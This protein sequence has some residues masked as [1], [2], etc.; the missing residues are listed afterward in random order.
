MIKKRLPIIL[1]GLILILAI[2]L[3]SCGG[4]DTPVDEPTVDEPSV[5]EP[6]VDEP[7]V[8]EPAAD[9][10]V[11]L[12]VGGVK[13]I[14]C[15]NLFTCSQIWDFGDYVFEGF[16]SRGRNLACSGEPRLAESMEVSEDGLT[17]TV[18]LREGITFSDGT[19]YNAHSA[20]E[21]ATWLKAN[22]DLEFWTLVTGFMTSAE[23]LDD[24][25]VQYTTE[26]PLLSFPNLDA[27]WWY[28]LPMHIWGDLEPD[29]VWNFEN[30]PPVGTGPYT[31]E[32]WK[33]GEYIIF[34]AREDYHLGKPP[35]DRIVY[36]IYSTWDGLIQAFLAD[37]IDLTVNTIPGVYYDTL[38]ADD[39]TGLLNLP[40]GQMHFLAFNSMEG[41]AKHQAID[42]LAIRQAIDL[43]ID[44]QH[45]VDIAMLGH[46]TTCPTSWACGE[47]YKDEVNPDLT[48][49]PYDPDEAKAILSDAGYTDSDGDGILESADG[50][51]L[52]FRLFYQ[53]EDALHTA[54]SQLLSDW[55]SAIGIDLEVVAMEV[56][57]LFD[58]I[59]GE[60]DY[61]IAL[62]AFT[63]DIDPIAMDFYYSCWSADAAAAAWNMGG[64]CNPEFDDAIFEA[65]SAAT[66]EEYED[67]HNRAQA[68]L[69]RDLPTL[70]IAGQNQLQAYHTGTFEFDT[71][72][73]AQHFGVWAYPQI[74]NVEVK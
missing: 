73:C 23:A 24:L 61:D 63:P 57:T 62:I 54:I 11:I 68:I 56:G 19:P 22:V 65:Q 39:N 38:A 21:Y 16:N 34:D 14:D 40:P 74:L 35:V 60:R 30:F 28:Q 41:G 50:T 15:W 18:H 37:E 71:E 47:A 48:V 1:L 29:D 59:L 52:E 44:K 6:A 58:V 67:A 33:P 72:V 32:D 27:I 26:V 10:P 36:Q 64:Y 31:V 8:D 51:P 4:T 45:V 2:G 7:A 13:D 66:I 17:W 43:A 12:R 69:A 55:F 3:S 70:M 46:G 49:T 20:V 25:T 53:A 9:E 5:D 42:D